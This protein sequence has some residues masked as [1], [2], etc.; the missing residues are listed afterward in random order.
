MN[1]LPIVMLLG[2][3]LSLSG[4]SSKEFTDVAVTK[5]IHLP[6][7]SL[8]VAY[9]ADTA[10]RELYQPYVEAALYERHVRVSEAARHE[11]VIVPLFIGDYMVY[12]DMS[13]PIRTIKP[14]SETQLVSKLD[15]SRSVTRALSDSLQYRFSNA[16]DFVDINE[17]L[18]SYGVSMAVTVLVSFALDSALDVEGWQMITDV[19]LDGERTRIFAH[20][21]DDSLDPEEAVAELTKRTARQIAL[22]VGRST[23]GEQ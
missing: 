8:R 11:L 14:L 12:N 18:R 20:T 23:K 6:A 1:Y 16:K 19:Y 9:A 2:I 15:R 21:F 13:N 10:Q 4:C 3:L 7:D 22:F 17:W 5:P